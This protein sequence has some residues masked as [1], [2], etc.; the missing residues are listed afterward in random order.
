MLFQLERVGEEEPLEILRI[1]AAV[2]GRI[3]V[4]GAN[5]RFLIA[6]AQ[7]FRLCP[8]GIVTVIVLI[9]TGGGTGSWWKCL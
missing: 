9:T 5:A 3:E 2:L 8:S 6:A 7:A 1:L 4:L